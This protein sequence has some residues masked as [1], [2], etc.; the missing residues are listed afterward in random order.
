MVLLTQ[1]NHIVVANPVL[2]GFDHS[3]VTVALARG[4]SL[5]RGQEAGENGRGIRGREG[6]KTASGGDSFV[7]PG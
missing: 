3:Q 7:T 4:P 5:S 2:T 1:V 6:S